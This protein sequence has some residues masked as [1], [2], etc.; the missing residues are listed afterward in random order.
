[1][2]RQDN[3]RYIVDFSDIGRQIAFYR[4]PTPRET[5]LLFVL[6]EAQG[7][8][9]HYDQLCSRLN[10]SPVSIQVSATRLRTKLV[11]DW[12]I[13][14]VSKRGLQLLYVPL[15]YRPPDIIK[16]D[17]PRIHYT[18]VDNNYRMKRGRALTEVTQRIKHRVRLNDD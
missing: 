6:A 16:P 10:K 3:I 15:P 17:D 9:V 13:H 4:P 5:N 14:G 1:M 12:I 2:S 8:E 18:V 11:E 7:A